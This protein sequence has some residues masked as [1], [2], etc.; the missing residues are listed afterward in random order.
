MSMVSHMA[1]AV[2]P[3]LDVLVYRMKD[4][5]DLQIERLMIGRSRAQ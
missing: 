3:C 2:I 1:I 4:R 5:E